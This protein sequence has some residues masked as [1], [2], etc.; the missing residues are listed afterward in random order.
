ME[1]HY[2]QA[3]SK[4]S[5]SSEKLLARSSWYR[6]INKFIASLAQRTEHVVSTHGVGGSN[7]P[8]SANAPLSQQ[9]EEENLKFFQSRFESGVGYQNSGR[10]AQ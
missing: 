1:K 7:P 5:Y 2:E 10:V 6:S 8:G 4:L 3:F 9:V